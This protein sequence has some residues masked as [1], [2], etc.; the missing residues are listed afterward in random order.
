MVEPWVYIS[1]IW[2][3]ETPLWIASNVVY[4]NHVYQICWRSV[5]GW[6]PFRI[7]VAGRPWYHGWCVICS[8]HAPLVSCSLRNIVQSGHSKARWLSPSVRHIFKTLLRL[9]SRLRLSTTR[10]AV[11]SL[12]DT[13]FSSLGRLCGAVYP[14]ELWL[15][16]CRCRFPF[17]RRLQLILSLTV[18][19]F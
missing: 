1:R 2:G 8:S 13:L 7:D 9:L 16:D 4:R 15:I 18:F 6:Q 14:S 19:M 5:K 10:T 11:I 3:E 12:S 17:P